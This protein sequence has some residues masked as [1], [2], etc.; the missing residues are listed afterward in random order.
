MREAGV[1]AIEWQRYTQDAPEW[2]RSM[3]ARRI[4]M[5]LNAASKIREMDRK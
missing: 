4:A 3:L 5:V 1:M 2:A